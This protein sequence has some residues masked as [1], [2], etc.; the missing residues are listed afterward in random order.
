[1]VHVWVHNTSHAHLLERDEVK[2]L[3]DQILTTKFN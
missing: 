2:Q 3:K 1:M